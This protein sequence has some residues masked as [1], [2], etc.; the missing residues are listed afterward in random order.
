[1]AKNNSIDRMMGGPTWQVILRLLVLSL[2]VGAVLSFIGWHPID[3]FNAII[4]FFSD[5]WLHGWEALGQVG[6]YIALGA[7][8]VVPIWLVSRLLSSKSD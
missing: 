5:L 1:M 6:R 3:M 8:V 7:M 2:I 4:R